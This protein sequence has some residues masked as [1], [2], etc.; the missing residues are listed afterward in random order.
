MLVTPP[1]IS[2]TN[3]IDL[4][5]DKLKKRLDKLVYNDSKNTSPISGIVPTIIDKLFCDPE[6]FNNNMG[7]CLLKTHKFFLKRKLSWHEILSSTVFKNIF[8]HNP[9]QIDLYRGIIQ[10]YLDNAKDF[11]PKKHMNSINCG[12]EF[13]Q[14]LKSISG[15]KKS[16]S[17]KVAKQPIVCDSNSLDSPLKTLPNEI[18]SHIIKITGNKSWKLVCRGWNNSVTNEENSCFVEK[19]FSEKPESLNQSAIKLLDLWMINTERSKKLVDLLIQRAKLKN[20]SGQIHFIDTL[21]YSW[22]NTVQ[23]K[24]GGDPDL[25]NKL[26]YENLSQYLCLN[27]L[28]TNVMQMELAF[29]SVFDRPLVSIVNTIS[30]M[31]KKDTPSPVFINARD[32]TFSLSRIPEIFADEINVNSNNSF[33]IGEIVAIITEG[34]FISPQK[35]LWFAKIVGSEIRN[36]EI[37]YQYVINFSKIY[38]KWI[39]THVGK[40]NMIGKFPPTINFQKVKPFLKINR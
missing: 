2:N 20:D 7:K 35:G 3:Y 23:E 6:S 40:A 37:W 4:Y 19:A 27:P 38:K 5:A 22:F 10:K 18:W 30:Q 9:E 31:N 17:L 1:I 14:H 25:K 32:T 28:C 12:R 21:V 8:S 13:L 39:Y 36:G 16:Q 15:E 24:K 26:A 34:R 33:E 11:D 29:L